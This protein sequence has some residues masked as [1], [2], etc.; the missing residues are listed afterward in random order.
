[1]LFEGYHPRRWKMVIGAIIPKPNKDD[2]TKPK[3]FCP[4]SL[5]SMLGKGLERVVAR[6]LMQAGEEE[7]LAD[8]QWG[9]RRG[10]AA[11]ECVAETVD[12]MQKAKEGGEC[13]VFAAA[14]IAQ[15]FPS[16][17]KHALANTLRK[18]KILERVV[19]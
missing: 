13:V 16:T 8:S 11:E 2:Y 5:L 3:S 10:R 9:G 19:R 15:A 1:M 14:N 7:G 18:N 17:A 6:R 4:I 12:W